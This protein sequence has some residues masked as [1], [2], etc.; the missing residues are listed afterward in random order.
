M[1]IIGVLSAYPTAA[2][3]DAEAAAISGV[4]PDPSWPAEAPRSSR[5]SRTRSDPPAA[6]SMAASGPLARSGFFARMAA[7]ASASSEDTARLRPIQ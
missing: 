5:S 7:A 6:A 3:D 2:P 1:R 4:N